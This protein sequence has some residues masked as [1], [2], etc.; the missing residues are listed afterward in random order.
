MVS[1]I[2]I[3]RG[4]TRTAVPK[5]HD[6]AY[7]RPPCRSGEG[8]ATCRGKQATRLTNRTSNEGRRKRAMNEHDRPTHRDAALRAIHALVPVQ[9]V[10]EAV[11]G[12]RTVVR[13]RRHSPARNFPCLPIGESISHQVVGERGERDPVGRSIAIR[14][15][16]GDGD[17]LHD[18]PW[19]RR[20]S[21][22]R[23]ID[24]PHPSTTRSMI[25]ALCM[26]P[27]GLIMHQQPLLA[28]AVAVVAIHLD[29]V[30]RLDENV[31]RILHRCSRCNLMPSLSLLLVLPG[32][33]PLLRTVF[34]RRRFPLHRL[35]CGGSGPD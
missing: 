12:T 16:R 27:N 20:R 32:A 14:D 4:R 7:Q 28:D 22:K 9:L 31:R 29:I 1:G 34:P 8:R 35:D 33:A 23:P 17:S 19:C 25:Q 30:H 10:V 21:R 5:N 24:I 15:G 3:L 2:R 13:V 26:L 11:M 18:P 6:P